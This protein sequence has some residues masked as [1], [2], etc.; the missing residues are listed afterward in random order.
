MTFLTSTPQSELRRTL[1]RQ[2]ARAR[3]QTDR[4]FEMLAPLAM[5]E[6]PIPERHRLV[7]Y[8]GHLEA[9]DWNMICS[10]SFGASSFNSQFDRLF[11]F[12]IDPIH[13]K[14]PQDQPGDWPRL[15]E[16]HS[17]NQRVRHTVDRFLDRAALVNSPAHACGN[18][19][20][21][22]ALV[23]LWGQRGQAPR[24]PNFKGDERSDPSVASASG[25]YPLWYCHVG[26]GNRW[27]LF[28]RM[29]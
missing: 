27:A 2:L 22:A 16:I 18:V 3:T 7:F 5:Y 15:E 20:L 1:R 10:A 29:G 25:R 26:P 21:Y 28:F 17:Y 4:L 23:A 19:S 9:F 6:R 8:L 11:A 14:L 12:G 13:G 24:P